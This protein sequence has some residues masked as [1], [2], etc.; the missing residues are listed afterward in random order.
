MARSCRYFACACG[1]PEAAY[2]ERPEIEPRIAVHDPVR[3]RVARAARSGDTG[4]KGAGDVEIV[5]FRRQ[6]HD[7]LAVGGDGN[8]SVDHRANADLVQHRQTFSGGECEQ[9][10]P[11]HVCGE[12]LPAEIERRALLPAAE[13]PVLPSADGEGS[14]D[15]R[16]EIEVL[17]RVAQG[18]EVVAVFE[19]FLGDEIL[20]L[21]D[22]GGKR[23][24]RH[25]ADALRPQA[26]AIDQHIAAD[27]AVVG[28]DTYRAP[29]SITMSSTQTPSSIFAPFRRAA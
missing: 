13:R 3:H 6:P 8:R 10:Q 4:G 25:L 16:L 17:V 26:G 21:D 19:P 1:A 5:E 27:R 15:I 12:Q 7:R 24:A 18:R 22:T 14:A 2:V 11:V 29:V 20:V 28:D 9:L 23:H